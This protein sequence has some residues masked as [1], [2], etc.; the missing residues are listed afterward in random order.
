MS[1]LTRCSL[2]FFSSVAML[3]AG[4]AICCGPYDYHYPTLGGAVQRADPVRGRVGSLFSD[5]G[6]FSGPPADYNVVTTVAQQPQSLETFDSDPDDL[7]LPDR[8]I[9]DG[10]DSDIDLDLDSPAESEGSGSSGVLPPPRTE[11]VTPPEP[12]D[13]TT[14]YRR[15]PV[16]RRPPSQSR[17]PGSRSRWR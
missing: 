10:L 6:P 3:F 11:N 12:A 15:G 8:D 13:D 2:A 14:L 7:E 5:P 16:Q 17:A 9:E 1:L 4:C